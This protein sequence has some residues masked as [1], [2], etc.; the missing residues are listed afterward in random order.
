MSAKSTLDPVT[1]T[2]QTAS[3]TRSVQVLSGLTR[4]ALAWTLLWAG[5]DKVFGLGH[6]TPSE[7]AVIKGVSPTA[8][9]LANA[10]N[11][12]GP[13]YNILRPMAGNPI[14]DVLFLGGLLGCGVAFLLGVVMRIA[15]VA[16]VLLFA[17]L[18][19][20]QLPLENNPFWDEHLFWAL[21]GLLLAA[22]GAG[23]YLGLGGWWSQTAFVRKY[24]IFA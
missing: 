7:G 18:W 10:L 1:S 8:G 4:L 15:S 19:F 13:A 14:V 12:E 24:P 22:L 11:P 9:F 16:A 17:S 6:P 5:L 21:T 3:P 2:T 20:S 23:R